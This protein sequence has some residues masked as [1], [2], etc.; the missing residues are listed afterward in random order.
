MN[1]P[2]HS[3]ECRPD[4]HRQSELEAYTA[5]EDRLILIRLI[6]TADTTLLN[7]I[8]DRLRDLPPAA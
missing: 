8:V 1:E 3:D 4:C 7:A 2:Q 6:A 5:N